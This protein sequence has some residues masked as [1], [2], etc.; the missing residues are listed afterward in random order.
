MASLD[1]LLAAAPDPGAAGTRLEQLRE[2][3]ETR[4]ALEALAPESLRAVV[5][6][7]SVSRFLFHFICRQPAAMAIIG[8]G[9]PIVAP[10]HRV[11]DP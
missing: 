10:A 7:I 2:D 3:S 1:H 9:T 11:T 5:N 6:L 8:T 4:R